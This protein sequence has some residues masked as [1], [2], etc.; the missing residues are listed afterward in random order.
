MSLGKP[1]CA[2][3]ILGNRAEHNILKEVLLTRSPPPPG[4]QSSDWNIQWGPV[5]LDIQKQQMLTSF[6][7]IPY[8]TTE[9]VCFL[10]IMYHPKCFI[11]LI[12]LLLLLG[13]R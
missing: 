1:S 5:S 2:G 8:G 7:L 6:G 11:Y 3:C 4:L 9:C 10:C 12:M 13:Y